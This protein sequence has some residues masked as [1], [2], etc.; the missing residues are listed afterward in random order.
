MPQK[1]AGCIG[2]RRKAERHGL[3]RNPRSAL[4]VDRRPVAHPR[5]TVAPGKT[6][7]FLG[8]LLLLYGGAQAQREQCLEIELRQPSKETTQS[9][10]QCARARCVRVS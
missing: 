4:R 7:S 3:L 8:P 10:Q 2:N 1:A 5:E 9:A 6:F